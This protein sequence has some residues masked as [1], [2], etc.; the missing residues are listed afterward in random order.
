MSETAENGIVQG[1]RRITSRELEQIRSTVELFPGLAPWELAETLCEHLGWQTAAG[2]NK[3]T[4]C[5][6]LLK[7][8]EERGLITMPAQRWSWGPRRSSGRPEKTDR[9]APGG[10]V[11][12]PL[13]ALG[14]VRLE[15]AGRGEAGVFGTSTSSG[16]TIWG[17]GSLLAVRCGTSRGASGVCWGACCLPG[18]RRRSR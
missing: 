7:S 12:G 17:T 4:A 16:T 3:A 2:G 5:M 8:L 14:P 9:T 13:A 1:G 18:L 11:S 6:K 15:L 10:E